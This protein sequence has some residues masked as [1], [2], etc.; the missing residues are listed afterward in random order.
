MV[1]AN[2]VVGAAQPQQRFHFFSHRLLR[3]RL[4]YSHLQICGGF[5]SAIQAEQQL[6]SLVADPITFTGAAVAQV[7]GVV[8]R[9]A[10]VAARHPRAAAYTPGVIL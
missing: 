7:E 4:A 3:G 8:R 9:V 2:D 10:E 1:K 6:A 5:S